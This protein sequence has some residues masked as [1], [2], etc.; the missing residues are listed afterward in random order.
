MLTQRISL[1]SLGTRRRE[2]ST[3]VN[4]GYC[5]RNMWP[6]G[7]YDAENTYQS[8]TASAKAGI[9]CRVCPQL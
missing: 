3:T 2:T 7:R 5:T 6:A 9:D 4:T 8:A 1:S